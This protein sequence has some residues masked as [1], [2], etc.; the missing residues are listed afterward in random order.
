MQKTVQK[1]HFSFLTGLFL[2][3]N[4][5]AVLL[6]LLAYLS[7]YINPES[8]SII[9]FFGLGYPI[10]LGINILFIVFW[11]FVKLR[12]GIISL[13]FILL[14]WNHIGRLVQI[15]SSTEI[16]KDLEQ[17][18]ILSYNIQ[19]FVKEN[20]SSTK[21]IQSFENQQKITEFIV[22]QKSDIICLQEVLYDKEDFADFS[23]QLGKKLN[24][25]N[26]YTRNYYPNRKN[27]V[28]ALAI[29]TKYPIIYKG[30]FEHL[31]KTIGIYCDILIQTDTVRL[32]NLHLA[33]IHFKKEEYDFITEITKQQDQETF[34]TNTLKVISKMNVA[35]IKRGKQT[36]IITT[37]ISSSPYPIILCG[38]FNDTPS[39]FAYRELSKNLKDAFVESGKGFGITYAGENFP[40]FRID[41]ILYDPQ[42][43]S[44]NFQKHKIA[45]SDH[46]PISYTLAID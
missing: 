23:N 17:V 42:F 33:S 31:E 46:Y 12:Y 26:T 43:H 36:N 10:I 27:K 7:V 11:A 25:Q 34:K 19:N 16:D 38:D 29:F 9:A 39:S 41:Y 28:D 44:G 24:C 32:Y 3:L 15:N 5:F 2:L 35:F 22:D 30:Y 21:Y 1:K 45:F 6:L 20:T 18:K 40:A 13:V 8:F 37:H 4:G 14:G